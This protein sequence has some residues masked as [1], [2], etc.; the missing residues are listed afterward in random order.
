MTPYIGNICAA[1][2]SIGLL[3]GT[4]RFTRRMSN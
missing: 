1:L 4:V 3:V 2:M